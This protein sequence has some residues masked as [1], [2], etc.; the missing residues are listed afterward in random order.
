MNVWLYPQEFEKRTERKNVN[1][2]AIKNQ[3]IRATKKIIGQIYQLSGQIAEPDFTGKG[4]LKYQNND[5]YE[6]EFIHGQPDG[7]G[8]IKLASGDEYSGQFTSGQRHGQGT[9]LFASGARYEGEWRQNKFHGSGL[10]VDED[11]NIHEGDFVANMRNG[12][13]KMTFAADGTIAVGTWSKNVLL[14]GQL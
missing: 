6:G 1:Q 7:K 9:M 8:T 13:G 11:G 10:L 14:E 3:P 2:L 4:T 12:R 5:E